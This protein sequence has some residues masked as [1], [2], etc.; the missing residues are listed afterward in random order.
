MTPHSC[1]PRLPSRTAAQGDDKHAGCRS[2]RCRGSPYSCLVIPGDAALLS[3][4][5]GRRL[6]ILR[7]V[8]VARGYA[9]YEMIKQ[10]RM[11]TPWASDN[12]LQSKTARSSLRRQV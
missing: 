10:L 6:R 12:G 8:V 9:R 11:P 5:P 7:E 3:R 2:V 1:G 4:H